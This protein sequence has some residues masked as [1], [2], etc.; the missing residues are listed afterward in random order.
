MG[1][2]YSGGRLKLV[3]TL[4]AVA[5]VVG[6]LEII[7]VQALAVISTP[8]DAGSQHAYKDCLAGSQKYLNSQGK[9]PDFHTPQF[10]QGYQDTWN[11]CHSQ[12]Q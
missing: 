6:L 1:S 12:S 10:N 5:V 2:I 4:M 7:P 8:Y 9:G 3:V 11:E